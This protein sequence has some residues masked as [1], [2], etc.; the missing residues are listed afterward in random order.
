MRLSPPDRCV[1]LGVHVCLGV[2]A[3]LV[4]QPL[5]LGGQRFWVLGVGEGDFC[6]PVSSRIRVEVRGL[7][8]RGADWLT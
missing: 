5:H 6:T 2:R 4:L 1:C 3:N 7:V 8:H